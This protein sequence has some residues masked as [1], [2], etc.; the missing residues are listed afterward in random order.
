[1]LRPRLWGA[2]VVAALEVPQ[3]PHRDHRGQVRHVDRFGR[4]AR[5]EV[6]HAVR[7]GETVRP[8]DAPS[9]AVVVAR[10]VVLALAEVKPPG[11]DGRPP[12][13][14]PLHAPVVAPVHADAL[15]TE[16]GCEDRQRLTLE[17]REALHVGGEDGRV[18]RGEAGEVRPQ[19]EEWAEA[20]HSPPRSSCGLSSARMS[21]LY[22]TIRRLTA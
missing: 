2:Q 14:A 22:L 9:R 5:A 19:R 10:G 12:E 20:G 16:L 21:M 7:S 3:A 13:Y 6:P 1:R 4:H 15:A 8:A 11:V 18:V 17:A